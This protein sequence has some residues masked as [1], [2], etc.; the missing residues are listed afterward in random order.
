MTGVG[1]CG[2]LIPD[3]VQASASGAN[4]KVSLFSKQ[5]C[6]NLKYCMD[7]THQCFQINKT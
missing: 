7:F 1:V 4:R 2:M 5:C 6:K 3:R